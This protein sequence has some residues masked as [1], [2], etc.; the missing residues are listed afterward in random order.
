MT[1]P[2]WKKGALDRRAAPRAEYRRG[3]PGLL[4]VAHLPCAVRDLGAGGL[5]VEPAPPVRVWTVEQPI[6]GELVLHT[7]LRVEIT[8]RIARIDRAGMAIVPVGSADEWPAD[9]LIDAERLLLVRRLRER[10]TAPRLPLPFS[11]QKLS[12]LRDVSE[13][14]LRYALRPTDAVPQVGSHLSGALR[15]DAET[16]IEVRGRVVRYGAREVAVAFD[17]PGLAPDVLTML[18]R[19]LFPNGEG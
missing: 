8:G 1:E 3:A 19:R 16:E 11:L 7:G 17:P 14:G 12:P 4:H 10:R 13:T 2:R 18:R 15:L 5:R 6:A 9:D